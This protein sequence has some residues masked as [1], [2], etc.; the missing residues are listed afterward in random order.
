M[1]S[2]EVGSILV[3]A[4][5]GS[6]LLAA[7]LQAEAPKPQC[8]CKKEPVEVRLRVPKKKIVPDPSKV[9]MHRR[10]NNPEQRDGIAWYNETNT[11]LWIL[12]APADTFLEGNPRSI[13]VPPR[14]WSRCYCLMAGV[15]TGQV[16]Y[17]VCRESTAVWGKQG[18]VVTGTKA[19]QEVGGVIVDD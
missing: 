10:P 6:F 3:M 16:D 8:D 7:S 11:K 5:I 9:H 15:D 18:F 17:Y 12:T 14:G 13:P 19:K 1:N 2:R 4:G